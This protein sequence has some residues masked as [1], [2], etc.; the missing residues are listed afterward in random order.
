MTIK[1]KLK[2][3][4]IRLHT[5]MSKQSLKDLMIISCEL[6]KNVEYVFTSKSNVLNKTLW[7]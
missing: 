4:K 1:S 7:Y 2:L 6:D 5:T 3:V